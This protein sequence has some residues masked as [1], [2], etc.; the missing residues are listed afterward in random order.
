M[1]VIKRQELYLFVVSV[2]ISVPKVYSVH[3]IMLPSQL[4]KEYNGVNV[5]KQ[6]N[7][8]T[9]VL[10]F[11]WVPTCISHIVDFNF[12]LYVYIFICF[13]CICQK[14]STEMIQRKKKRFS[15]TAWSMDHDDREVIWQIRRCV[16]SDCLH[17]IHQFHKTKWMKQITKQNWL[18]TP[19]KFVRIKNILRLIN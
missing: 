15:V 9:H 16:S 10:H 8:T 12:C 14:E 11:W 13:K 7:K 18:G 6:R 19:S 2:Q 3:F 4:N 5:R 17:E 1:I